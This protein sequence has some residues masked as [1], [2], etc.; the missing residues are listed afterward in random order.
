VFVDYLSL[1]AD[2]EE[3]VIDLLSEEFEDDG[4]YQNIKNP[5]ATTWLVSFEQIRHRDP[6]AADY[7]SFMCCIDSK[8]IPRSLLP[9]GSSRKKEMEAIGTLNAY[10]FISKRPPNAALD[11]YRLVY[12]STRNWLRKENLLAQ[13]TERVIVRL[14]EVFPDDD[15][16]NRDV[17]RTYLP[18]AHYI[19]ESRLVVMDSQSRMDLLRKYGMCLFEDGRWNEAEDAITEV[20]EIEKRDLGTDHSSTLLSM[21]NLAMAY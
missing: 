7:L 5:V 17:W 8:D 3:A 16:K 9:P 18:H 4:R 14:E 11:L 21:G 10:S 1:L 2:Q 15:Y 12:L 13:S 20:L 19:L 6:L